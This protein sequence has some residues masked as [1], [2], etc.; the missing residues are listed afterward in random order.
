[1]RKPAKGRPEERG[2][3]ECSILL[4]A[5]R[6]AFCVDAFLHDTAPQTTTL[7]KSCKF[8]KAFETGRWD[9]FGAS[10]LSFRNSSA[11]LRLRSISLLTIGS[12]LSTVL[13]NEK[14]SL[15]FCISSLRCFGA[16]RFSCATFIV[17][18]SISE[19]SSIAFALFCPIRRL[20]S[21]FSSSLFF[22][23]PFSAA[24]FSTSFFLGFGRHIRSN[25]ACSIKILQEE[26]NLN[27]RPQLS[28]IKL[29]FRFLKSARSSF[30]LSSLVVLLYFQFKF[31]AT[32]P[33]NATHSI[34][35]FFSMHLIELAL[36]ANYYA[37]LID[38][39]YSAIA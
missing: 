26:T 31:F 18:H 7:V 20:K 25:F 38:T 23:S 19:R 34:R 11:F 24:L 5:R 30:S 29:T 33:E 32:Q 12:D 14:I 9:L 17:L 35:I 39:E 37:S 10:S 8:V 36:K 1:M 15:C 21:F 2:S 22:S 27:G 4:V 6:R 16:L 13:V 28:V 3:G